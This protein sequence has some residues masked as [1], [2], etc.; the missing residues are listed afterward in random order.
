MIN[1]QA[2]DMEK[3]GKITKNMEGRLKLAQAEPSREKKIEIQ[4]QKQNFKILKQSVLLGQGWLP[5]SL[6]IMFS[7]SFSLLFMSFVILP[8]FIGYLLLD[9]Y[10]SLDSS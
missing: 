1:Q 5:L 9:H 6:K 7:A 3:A 4:E 2:A 8:V 10:L